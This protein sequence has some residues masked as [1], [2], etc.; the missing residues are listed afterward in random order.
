MSSIAM[1][2]AGDIALGYSVSSAST[3]P[4]IAVTG[5]RA[6]D[7]L[8]V[9]TQGETFIARGTRSQKRSVRWGDYSGMSVDPSDGTTFWYTSELSGYRSK[10]QTKIASFG[11]G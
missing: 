2:A 1:N 11:L 8:G 10:W 7:D 6:G 5:R 4:S 3:F 9:M